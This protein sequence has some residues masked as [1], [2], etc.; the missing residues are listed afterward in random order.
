VARRS[1]SGRRRETDRPQRST[2]NAAGIDLSSWY[3]KQ[4]RLGCGDSK[5]VTSWGDGKSCH[6]IEKVFRLAVLGMVQEPNETTP[7][8]PACQ[9]CQGGGGQSH[10]PTG[11]GQN[12][13]KHPYS[14]PRIFRDAL[15]WPGLHPRLPSIGVACRV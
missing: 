9:Q 14:R 12:I 8:Q 3:L 5:V 7:P 2:T 10:G 6:S 4:A 11:G 15:T 13:V 1:D